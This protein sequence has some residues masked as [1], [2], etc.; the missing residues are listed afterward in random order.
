[1][2]WLLIV[3]LVYFAGMMIWGYKRGFARMVVSIAS[4]I[5]SVVLVIIIVP[6]VHTVIQENTTWEQD[7]SKVLQEQIL[8]KTVNSQTIQKKKQELLSSGL[9]DTIIAEKIQDLEELGKTG[10]AALADNLA[11]AIFSILLFIFL[12]ILIKLLL[13]ILTSVLKLV[14]KIPGIHQI[15]GLLGLAI[16]L[17]EAILFTWIAC[18]VIQI[19]AF[20]SI[21]GI[22]YTEIQKSPFLSFFCQKN[23][24]LVLLADLGDVVEQIKGL[25]V[26]LSTQI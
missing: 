16:G 21:G 8:E 4:L 26:L 1:M 6:K 7:L 17:I 20:T 22:L 12:S 18:M 19:F 2:S 24:L 5:L 15:N 3:A 13:E 14:T 11:S 23:V 10:V 9:K 25:G